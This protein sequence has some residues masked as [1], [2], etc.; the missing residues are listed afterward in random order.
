MSVQ[1]E[2]TLMRW[3]L[4]SCSKIP[5]GGVSGVPSAEPSVEAEGLKE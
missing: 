4:G 3:A 2:K 1:R 5:V